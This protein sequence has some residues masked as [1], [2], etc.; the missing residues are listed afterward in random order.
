MLKKLF[1]TFKATESA[2]TNPEEAAAA[3]A[4]STPEKVAALLAR[5]DA[6]I[7]AAEPK[8]GNQYKLLRRQHD[9]ATLAALRHQI[10]AERQRV[11]AVVKRD[12][13]QAEKT[14]ADANEQHAGA[15][16]RL[17]ALQA[18]HQAAA[19][20][21]EPLE[22][23]L[24]KAKQ[25][26]G[27][28]A[29]QAQ[30]AFDAAIAKGDEVAET[31][32]AETLYQAQEELKRGGTLGGPLGLRIG[33]LRRELEAAA[34]AVDAAA[35]SVEEA[36]HACLRAKAELAFVEYDRQAQALLD[37]YLAQRA[38]AAACGTGPKA[39]SI[40]SSAAG[41]FEVQICSPERIVNGRRMDA[42][43]KRVLPGSIVASLLDAVTKTPNLKVLAARV[44]DLQP[45]EVDESASGR[46]HVIGSDGEVTEALEHGQ[47][48]QQ[49]A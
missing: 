22:A 45:D 29:V 21:L 26:A 37:A 1:S 24:K 39:R 11:A 25:Q 43:N 15:V 33:A 28:R 27:E 40:N 6:E 31:A 32:A 19:D 2:T 38:A 17:G 5:L 9:Q 4:I 49:F 12:K 30:K 23:E 41:T 35:G 36:E 8:F 34:A 13:A 10:E 44:E 47:A 20:R 18:K 48:P 3:D 7:A 16:A 14:L 42:Y 46:A